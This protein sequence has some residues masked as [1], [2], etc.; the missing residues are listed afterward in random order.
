ML[1]SPSQTFHVTS[2]SVRWKA[3]VAE[4]GLKESKKSKSGKQ[5]R[6]FLEMG[7]IHKTFNKFKVNLFSFW[8]LF[9]TGI[10]QRSD[11]QSSSWTE[12]I[13]PSSLNKN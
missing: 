4:N 12:Y 3:F 5:I 7:S 9:I 11:S 10:W 8:I 1:F 13:G 6:I 2:S